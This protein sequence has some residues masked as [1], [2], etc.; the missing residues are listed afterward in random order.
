M[1][2]CL[3]AIIMLMTLHIT[4]TY[5]QITFVLIKKKQ[6]W[7]TRG[8]I[9]FLALPGRQRIAAAAAVAAKESAKDC[10]SAFQGVG[11]S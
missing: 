2:T 8:A 11:R 3:H 7:S 9:S 6:T 10:G 1:L 5:I 4:Y